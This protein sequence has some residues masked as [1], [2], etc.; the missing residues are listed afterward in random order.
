M[1]FDR[2]S[3]S[4]VLVP[5]RYV[6]SKPS[7]TVIA[8]VPAGRARALTMPGVRLRRF[9]APTPTVETALANR[10]DSTNP[11]VHRLAALLP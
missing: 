5:G 6:I 10:T 4:T 3:A 7:R 1:L 11:A 2:I 8:P 9:A